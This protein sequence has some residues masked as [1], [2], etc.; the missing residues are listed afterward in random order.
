M[1]QN[2]LQLD[3]F[4]SGFIDG[5]VQSIFTAKCQKVPDE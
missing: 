4:L 2:L 5:G 3:D 1:D